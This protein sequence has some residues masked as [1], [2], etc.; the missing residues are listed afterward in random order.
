MFYLDYLF[1]IIWPECLQTTW[2]SLV[3][4]VVLTNLIDFY[5]IIDYLKFK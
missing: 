1:L 3:H 2:I 4:F 5:Q